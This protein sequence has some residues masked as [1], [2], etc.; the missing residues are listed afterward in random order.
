VLVKK[1]TFGVFL[2]SLAAL[3]L[4]TLP[5]GAGEKESS[6]PGD[7]PGKRAE[8]NAMFRRDAEGRLS[9]ENRLRALRQA[10]ELPVDASMAAVPAGTFIRSDVG[11][12]APKSSF[13]GTT[14]QSVGPLP[15]VYFEGSAHRQYGNVGGRVDSIAVHPTNPSI[16]LL[17]SATGGIWKSTDGGANWRPVSDYAPSLALSHVAFSPANPSIVF[18]AT[19]EADK[20]LSGSSLTGS[21]GTYLG[22]GLLK[23][24]DGGETW[25]RVDTNLPE[26]AIIS[27][28]VPHPFDVQK[29]TVGIFRTPNYGTGGFSIGGIYRST[30]GGVTFTNTYQHRIADLVPDPNVPERLFASTGGCGNCTTY[31]VLVSSDFG[32]TWQATSL[33]F[34]TNHSNIKLGISRTNPAV[35]Y[36]SILFTDYAHEGSPNAGIW[37]SQDAGVTWLKKNV[38][39]QMCP[40]TA[41]KL[42]NNQCYYDH[43][44]T[45]D[46]SNPATAYFGSISLYRTTDFGGTWVKQA[47]VYPTTGVATLHP[48]QHTGVFGGPGELLIGN[49]GGVY[50]TRDGGV[51]F[52]NLNGTLNV[53]QFNGIGLHPTNREFAIGGTQDNG[54]QRYTGSMTWT[55]RTGGDGGFNLIRTDDPSKVLSGY[56]E[57]GTFYSSDGGASF[58][59][60][61]PCSSSSYDQ[62]IDCA[63]PIAFYPPAAAVPGAPGT[64]LFGTNRVWYNQTFGEDTAEWFSLTSA[65]ITTQTDEYLI[66]VAASSDM[67]GA[68]WAG[69]DL[70]S[71]LVSPPGDPNFYTI[72][73]GPLPG[74][75][76]TRI[77]PASADGQ[78]AYVTFAGYLGSPSRHVFRTTNGGLS[79]TNI[80]SNLPDVPVLAMAVDPT[81]PND[82]FV[83]T[84]VGVFRS[85]NGGA[86]WAGFNSGLPNVP[87]YDLKFHALTKDLWAATYGRGVWRVMAPGGRPGT[88]DYSGDGQADMAVYRP[89]TG[90]WYALTA[91]GAWG[92][93]SW[94]VSGDVPVPADYDGDG[95]TNVAVFRPSTGTWYVRGYSTT[96]WGVSTDIPVPGDFDGDGKADVAVY[97]PGTGTWFV[98]RSSGGTTARTWGQSGDTPVSG[99]FD[100]DGKADYAV[101]RRAGGVLTWYVLKSGGGYTGYDAVQWGLDGDMPAPADYDGDGKADIAAF[102]PSTGWWYI[103]RSSDG[104]VTARQWGVSG[105]VPQPADYEG[106]GKADIA[107]FRPGNGAWYVIKSSDGGVIARTWG[108]AGDVPVTSP[109]Y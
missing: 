82:L 21:F 17:G 74:A 62:S 68:L 9:A 22:G 78:T 54:N 97:R 12:S 103:R 43:F 70:G 77:V 57:Q 73:G 36:A 18:A 55:D 75:P 38:D 85:V 60:R 1:L 66:S 15:M 29:V 5:L 56:V 86:S 33:S 89:G 102:R 37:V 27:R 93:A 30:N 100:G 11:P 58:T 72:G 76:V 83:G 79:F 44:I 69:G 24:T 98:A 95:V 96:A 87:V 64:V 104:G 99:D 91:S 2:T 107:V 26:D 39:P 23:S 45:P 48:D 92:S 51:T 20:G 59:Y 35:L 101:V 47:D 3:A 42:G 46:P 109:R 67:N 61:V 50:R 81:D 90:V 4:F 28:V 94:G 13:G 108:V 34:S 8:W 19:G 25:F 14:W 40:T 65:A 31:G 41:A 106:D 84:D 49:D 105:D 7:H 63:D 6:E 32:A 16:I 10:C 80:S 88:G 52:E 71:L 53:S